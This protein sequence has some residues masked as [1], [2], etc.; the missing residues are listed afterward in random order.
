[1]LD[2]QYSNPVRVV[3]F[4]TAQ[5]WSKEVSEDVAHELRRRCAEQDRDLPSSLEQFVDL[6]Q[7][8]DCV[9]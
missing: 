8:Q 7:A 9:L 4:N 6:Y 2:G 1:L 5:G 3:A